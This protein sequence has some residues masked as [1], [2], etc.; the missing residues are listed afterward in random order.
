MLHQR[1]PAEQGREGGLRYVARIKRAYEQ[2]F[3]VEPPEEEYRDP[4]SGRVARVRMSAAIGLAVERRLER[5]EA[6]RKER[7]ARYVAERKEREARFAE[8]AEERR[9]RLK[10]ALATLARLERK[11]E[12]R[13]AR[14][15]RKA[16]ERKAKK[17]QAERLRR[18]P[19]IVDRGER[20]EVVYFERDSADAPDETRYAAISAALDPD[21]EYEMKVKVA[22]REPGRRESLKTDEFD[23][24]EEWNKLELRNGKGRAPSRGDSL[25]PA[26]LFGLEEGW[27]LHPPGYPRGVG[28]LVSLAPLG[29]IGAKWLAMHE[30]QENCVVSAV[31]AVLRARGIYTPK[32]EA[33][34][35]EAA[36]RFREKG[37]DWDEVDWLTTKM[38]L[39]I[40]VC[41]ASG[42]RLHVKKTAKGGVAYAS[43]RGA[44]KLYR[45]NGHCSSGEPCFGDV[46]RVAVY[47]PMEDGAKAAVAL[48]QEKGL[49]RA[50][51]VGA[52][53]LADD[54]TLWRPVAMD[55]A[56]HDWAAKVGLRKP[57]ADK[58]DYK[59]AVDQE[60]GEEF[61]EADRR[62]VGS[63]KGHMFRK[64]LKDQRFLSLWET[65]DRKHW[66]ASAFEAAHWADERGEA[67]CAHYDMRAAYL[68]C[69]KANGSGPARE[70]ADRFGFPAGGRQRYARADTIEQA[71]GLK[72]AI[73][74]R[75]FELST[76]AHPFIETQLR[77]HFGALGGWLTVPLAV[78]LREKGLVRSYEIERVM[79]S[80]ASAD[81]IRF[82]TDRNLAVDHV[83]RCA[84]AAKTVCFFTRD[85]A[86]KD[87]FVRLRNAMSAEME[88]GFLLSYDDKTAK[89][90]DYSYLR[91]YILSYMAIGMM[92]AVMALGDQVRRCAVD[93][94]WVAPGADM[95]AVPFSD[96]SDPKWGEFR[97]KAAPKLQAAQRG[98]MGRVAWRAEP[99]DNKDPE[100]P[101]VDRTRWATAYISPAGFGKTTA[102]IKL[103]EGKSNVVILAPTNPG[104]QELKEKEKNPHGFPVCTY[105][106]WLRLGDRD[107]KEWKPANMGNR[108]FV[109]AIVWD[110]CAVVDVG[111]LE[112]VLAWARKM[113]IVVI[114]CGDPLGQQQEFKD[115]E[116]GEKVMALVERLG[117]PVVEH[118]IDWRARNCPALQAAKQ[119]AWC[120][121]YQTQVEALLSVAERT[122]SGGV[123]QMWRPGDLV[124]DPTRRACARVT[125]ELEQ[126]AREFPE[127]PVR[128]RFKPEERQ[129]FRK[130]KGVLPLV[131]GPGGVPVEAA[132]GARVVAPPGTACPPHWVPDVATTV[133]SVQGATIKAPH[134]IFVCIDRMGE[135]WCRNAVYVA[136][137]RAEYASQLV[138]V[139]DED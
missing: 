132:I 16:A 35:D 44:I 25:T 71:A 91:A 9:R 59:W 58:A 123:A 129:P 55:E 63:L 69:D 114:L 46:R 66:R 40:E 119:K 53:V 99:Q 42:E 43:E 84:Y 135:D 23:P 18:S 109:D 19:Y 7:I 52:E 83:G 4:R 127:A 115:P 113:G 92:S 22:G 5:Q 57:R 88:G 67:D 133:R 111:L 72:G 95:R 34:L 136:M 21:V 1:R 47:S 14:R 64:W 101:P 128:Y 104:V 107:P 117:I 76:A 106:E 130:V 81:G 90:N 39:P 56:L 54:G 49:H 74:F 112:N 126:K 78:W 102:A 2:A 62:E 75:R 48:V 131:E 50:R 77:A 61:E 100:L 37:A 118:K 41:D 93:A 30:G 13:K 138:A 110:E 36:E 86:E 11:A 87:H 26:K 103:F 31:R 121:S 134:R 8:A 33:A 10:R 45:S 124:I 28:R 82:P 20:G 96:G 85:P 51:I 27:R 68:A 105:H 60:T 70:A 6:E 125:K 17:A 3:G 97:A 120:Q 116:S 108:A 89:S 12:K 38:K 94:V 79:Y 139:T 24:D 80:T 65:D 73:L 137:S 29:P 15:K 32:R 98:K 122:H